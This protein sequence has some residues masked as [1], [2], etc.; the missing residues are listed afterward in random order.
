MADAEQAIGEARC[1]WT[2]AP[3]LCGEC[4]ETTFVRLWEMDRH[5]DD[6]LGRC[7]K[8]FAKRRRA[9]GWKVRR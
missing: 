3:Q 5:R 9:N 4:G 6:G 2:D 7:Q 1:E 8:C